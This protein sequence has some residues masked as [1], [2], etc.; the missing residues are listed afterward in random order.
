MIDKQKRLI[1]ITFVVVLI[2][3]IICIVLL[4]ILNS[5]K[6]KDNSFDNVTEGDTIVDK[7]PIE[8]LR[9]ATKF[10]SVQQYIKDSVGESFVAKNMNILNE[11]RLT[12][13]AVYGEIT[14]KDSGNIEDIY[15]I[16]RVDT[17]NNTYLIEN[18][19][20]E[21]NS[22]DEI[23]LETD[24]QEISNNGNND[25]E[26]TTVNSENICRIYLENFTSLELNNPQEAYELID[27]EYREKRFPTFEEYQEYIEQNKE[28][29]QTGVLYQYSVDYKEDYTEYVLVD[30]FN[31]TYMLDETSIMNYTIKLD[32]Y[33]IKVD[34][35]E[36]EYNKL[37]DE[38]KVQSNVYIFLQMIN[39]KDYKHAYELLDN[40]FKN[41]NFDTVEKFENYI[42]QNFFSYNL[43]ST[44]VDIQKEANYYIYTSILRNNSGSAAE[45]KKL[46]VIMELLE[47]TNFVMSFSIE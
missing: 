25:F 20:E 34:S 39:T 12:S 32:N 28:I 7:Y 47:E 11:Y 17:E 45:T 35:Y 1:K 2:I 22:I 42:K 26:Y 37:S 14:D 33:T 41:N 21:Y 43:N 6:M 36:E 23:N 9:D 44:D 46:T 15:L 4:Y 30:N 8:K 13:F 19:D 3:C 10:F 16:F 18:L 40:T 24:L 31:N 29:I 27:T 5:N 38:N